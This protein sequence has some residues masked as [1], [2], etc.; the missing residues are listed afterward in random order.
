VHNERKAECLGVRFAWAWL[1]RTGAFVEYDAAEVR[2][3][4][5]DDSRRPA[6]YKLRGTC[7]LD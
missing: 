5:L 2:G 6:P 1:K 3:N 7:S 4:L